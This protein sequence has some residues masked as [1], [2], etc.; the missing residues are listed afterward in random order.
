MHNFQQ[1]AFV[2]GFEGAANTWQADTASINRARKAEQTAAGAELS[3]MSRR[4]AELLNRSLSVELANVVAAGEIQ[5]LE[6]R[7]ET[8]RQKVAAADATGA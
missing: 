7:R 2:R 4:W 1:E 5:D 3:R 6:A 8:L